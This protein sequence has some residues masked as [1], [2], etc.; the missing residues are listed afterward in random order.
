MKINLIFLVV[1]SLIFFQFSFSQTKISL[2]NQE[3][4]FSRIPQ[5]SSNK[6]ISLEDQIPAKFWANFNKSADKSEIVRNVERLNNSDQLKDGMNFDISY[7]KLP[8]NVKEVIR[9]SFPEFVSD[10]TIKFKLTI[11]GSPFPLVGKRKQYVKNYNY[12]IETFYL[13]Q[14]NKT[15]LPKLP[16]WSFIKQ[17]KQLKLTNIEVLTWNEQKKTYVN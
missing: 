15:P 8:L 11:V 10:T 4:K 5:C 12:S 17:N 13:N 14:I 16:T 6:A 3:T 1:L 9:C 2:K 7:A